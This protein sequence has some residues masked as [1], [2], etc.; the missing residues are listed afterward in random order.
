MRV[1]VKVKNANELTPPIK[2]LDHCANHLTRLAEI[3]G[4]SPK[5]RAELLRVAAQF[6]AAVEVLR[7]EEK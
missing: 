5:L 4:T 1:Q 7:G 3:P 6:R 2:A